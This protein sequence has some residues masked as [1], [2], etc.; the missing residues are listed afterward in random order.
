MKKIILAMV[1]TLSVSLCGCSASNTASSQQDE[2]DK[3]EQRIA[4]L[5]KE[6][7]ELKSGMVE[8]AEVSESDTKETA[9]VDESIGTIQI[10]D[11]ITTDR[12]EI[13]IKNIEFSYDVLPDDTSS[14]YTHYPANQGQVYI[15]IDTDVK[16]LQKQNLNAD[17]IMTVEADYNNGYNYSAF[18]IPEDPT[19]GFTYANIVVINPLETRGVRFLI[20]CP[21]E[22][23]ES[24]NPLSLIFAVDKEQF[25]YTIR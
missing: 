12:V 9:S 25:K 14:M 2:I 4:E 13:T 5:E 1:L 17:D 21:Q 8:E 11:V 24:E 16:N 23:E 7:T 19:T 3:L 18:P 15:H 6:N 20:D 22:V 10:G